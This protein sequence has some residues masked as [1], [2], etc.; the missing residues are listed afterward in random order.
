LPEIQIAF[1]CVLII[2]T[3]TGFRLD[4]RLRD[5][6]HFLQSGSADLRP[7][8]RR[9][10]AIICPRLFASTHRVFDLKLADFIEKRFI[11]W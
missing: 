1:Y 7:N 10:P 3:K 2:E 4:R 9:F 5:K 6:L 8:Q 11:A